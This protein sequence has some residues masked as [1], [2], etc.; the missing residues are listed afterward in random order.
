MHLAHLGLRTSHVVRREGPRE[1]ADAP[2]RLVD[3]AADCGHFARAISR[4]ATRLVWLAVVVAAAF[5][6]GLFLGDVGVRNWVGVYGLPSST[7]RLLPYSP[8]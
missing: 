3:V 6:L 4:A 2:E 7:L 1:L 8:R 5:G